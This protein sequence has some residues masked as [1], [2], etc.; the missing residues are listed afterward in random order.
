MIRNGYKR[1]CKVNAK[2][3]KEKL[4]IARGRYGYYIQLAGY[5]TGYQHLWEMLP[6]EARELAKEMGAICWRRGEV[7]C[8]EFE[9]VGK[10][11]LWFWTAA[12]NEL[13][14]DEIMGII[15]EE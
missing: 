13:I 7:R 11:V 9:S 6:D 14:P 1:V 3:G 8:P 15:M 5:L 10:L 4:K 2:F 12:K